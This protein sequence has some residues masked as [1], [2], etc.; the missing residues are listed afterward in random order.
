MTAV[1]VVV[2]GPNG[3]G[4]TTIAG[5]LAQRLDGHDGHP[6]LLTTEP[7]RSPLGV[8][9][10]QSE[11]SLRGRS[12]ALAIAAD[13]IHHV[14][15]EIMPALAAGRHVVSDRYVQSS[16]VLQRIDGL[17]TDEIWT[18]NQHVPKAVSF[19]LED[20]PDVIAARLAARD[21]LSRLEVTGSPQI[22]LDYY[23][24]AKALLGRHNWT[25]HTI[26]CHG[27]TPTDIVGDILALLAARPVQELP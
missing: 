10:R 7:T 11:G 27:R 14:E 3:V 20:D 26:N 8:L 23:R 18:Y 22:E 21:S 24:D 19:Y 17:D 15:T 1:F 9:L 6:V 4:K 13:R 25:Q 12:F 16:L 2:E 5:L